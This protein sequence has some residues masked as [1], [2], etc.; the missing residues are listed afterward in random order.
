MTATVHV[1]DP[2]TPLPHEQSF[3]DK[4]A[5]QARD[6]LAELN[7]GRPSAHTS[8]C[9][10]GWGGRPGQTAGTTI[11]LMALY[12]RNGSFTPGPL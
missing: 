8:E 5:A 3:Y 1:L 2:S 12:N 11:W 9:H 7:Q 4:E 6:L 10:C